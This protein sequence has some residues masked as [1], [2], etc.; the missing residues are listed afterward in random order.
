ML[1]CHA[2]DPSSI[3]GRIVGRRPMVSLNVSPTI[4]LNNLLIML[5]V[6]L[7]IVFNPIT[8]TYLII[9]TL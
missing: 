8:L 4:P 3:L 1:A 9:R 5:T 7:I 2:N 6:L